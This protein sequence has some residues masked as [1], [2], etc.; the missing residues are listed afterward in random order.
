[1]G[2]LVREGGFWLVLIGACIGGWLC[3]GGFFFARGFFFVGSRLCSRVVSGVFVVGRFAALCGTLAVAPFVDLEAGIAAGADA[4]FARAG[5]ELGVAGLGFTD[6]G[7]TIT[8]VGDALAGDTGTGVILV[9]TL[10]V[11]CATR[12][13]GVEVD[14]ADAIFTGGG[15][16]ARLQTDAEQEEQR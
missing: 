11:L 14:G 13:R 9:V 7:A 1:M 2:R 16:S 5:G 12:V 6:G 15:F 3:A 4:F 10:A 8:G